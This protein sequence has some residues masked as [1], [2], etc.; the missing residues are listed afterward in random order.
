MLLDAECATQCA[1]PPVTTCHNLALGGTADA[2]RRRHKLRHVALL[3]TSWRSVAR[4]GTRWHNR[5]AAE[6]PQARAC[7]TPGHFLAQRG[8]TWHRPAMSVRILHG[9]PSLLARKSRCLAGLK[10]GETAPDGECAIQCAPRLATPG[11][12][13]ARVGTAR[14]RCDGANG[15]EY[16]PGNPARERSSAWSRRRNASSAAWNYIGLTERWVGREHQGACSGCDRKQEPVRAT[17]QTGNCAD[18]GGLWNTGTPD[19]HRSPWLTVTW[20]IPP[21]MQS[22]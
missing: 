9:P 4:P 11:H 13:L 15:V 18:S 12:G 8:T 14:R 6:T 3:G 17:T 1:M 7:G 10:F 16:A 21:L 2:P 19:R 5:E 22:P 20:C